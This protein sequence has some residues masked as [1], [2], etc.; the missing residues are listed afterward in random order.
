M[1]AR[2]IMQALSRL[3]NALVGGDSRATVSARTGYFSKVKRNRYWR[4]MET[5]ID[6]TFYPLDGPGHCK[7]SMESDGHYRRG[8]DFGL[9][10]LSILV[11]V[12]C[13]LLLPITHLVGWL[14]RK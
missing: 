7:Q 11:P 13:L 9:T 4:S 2:N 3:L 14:K 12:A 5:V 8:N 6:F 1:W 10:A